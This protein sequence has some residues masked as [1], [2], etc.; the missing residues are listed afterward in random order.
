MEKRY[1]TENNRQYRIAKQARVTIRRIAHPETVNSLW[2]KIMLFLV[3]LAKKYQNS[4]F[5][6]YIC[7]IAL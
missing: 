3:H 5:G 4:D 2:R 6:C 7:Q 1:S